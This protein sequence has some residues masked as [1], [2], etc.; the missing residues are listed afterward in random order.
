MSDGGEKLHDITKKM[1]AWRSGIDMYEAMGSIPIISAILAGLFD[2]FFMITVMVLEIL[3]ILIEAVIL[4]VW[5]IIDGLILTPIAEQCVNVLEHMAQSDIIPEDIIKKITNELQSF[6]GFANVAIIMT[7]LMLMVKYATVMTE[8]PM[9]YSQRYLMERFRP[10]L[11]SPN[12]VIRSSFIAPEKT[13]RVWEIL[14]QSGY[15]DSDIELMFLSAYA[16]YDVDS[17]RGLFL[18]GVLS[19]DDMFVRMR[20]LGFTD[21]RTKEIKELWDIIPPV[22]EILY[23]VGKEAFEPDQVQKY[24]LMDEFPSE[25]SP[26]LEKHGYSKYWQ[27]KSWIS[28]WSYP[29]YQQVLQLLHRGHITEEDVYEFYRVIEIPPVWRNLLT[30]ISYSPY[31]RVDSRRMHA[32]GVLADDE[33]VDVYKAQGYD[34]EHATKMAEF[35]IKYNMDADK[36]LTKSQLE[37]GYRAGLLDKEEMLIMLIS[38][39]YPRKSAEYIINYQD[40]KLENDYIKEYI[41]TIQEL[42]Q[43]NVL[44]DREVSVQLYKIDLPAKKVESLIKKWDLHRL[45]NNKLPSKSDLDAFLMNGIIDTTNYIEVMQKLGY[46]NIYINWYMELINVQIMEKLLQLGG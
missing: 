46:N 45:Q 24:G 35:T 8:I 44:N 10:Q 30:K 27:D 31:T 17:I 39:G 40:W 22:S 12:E 41:D 6:G 38:I 18:R 15:T 4:L 28:H 9:Y 2:I 1:Q 16:T 43:N 37:Q 7:T 29:S 21:T 11:P 5:G 19:E 33:L 25:V 26:W 34:L 14:A 36:Q 13:K 42:Y 3:M 23:M 20:E 32:V